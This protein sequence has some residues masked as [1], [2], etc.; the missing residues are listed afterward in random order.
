MASKS[1][2]FRG[3][4]VAWC[5]WAVVRASGALG[6]ELSAR[7]QAAA[8]VAAGQQLQ[9][10]GDLK[11][12][13]AYFTAAIQ[14]DPGNVNAYVHRGQ[15]KGRQTPPDHAGAV[16]DFTTAVQLD[17]K[18]AWAYNSRATAYMAVGDSAKA[19]ADCNRAIE[20]APTYVT[21][22]HNRAL[23]RE[24]AGDLAGAWQDLQRALELDPTNERT[25]TYARELAV[26]LKKEGVAVAPPAKQGP[27]PA[28][29]PADPA[30]REQAAAHVASGCQLKGKGD[31]RGAIAFFDA[32]IR[33]DPGNVD[34]YVQR[35]QCKGRL[36]PPDNAG[37]LAD[38]T[39]ALKLNP[40]DA[41][42][43]NSR[44]TTYMAMGDL[45]RAMADCNRAIEI[46]PSYATPYQNRSL[47]R[48][49]T[50]DLAGAWQD[51]QRALELAPTDDR[52]LARGRQLA[53][54]LKREGVAVAPPPAKEEPPAVVVAPPPVTPDTPRPMPI[55]PTTPVV[56]PPDGP[57]SPLPPPPPRTPP[58]PV[59]FLP[60]DPNNVATW[61]LPDTPWRKGDKP[62]PDDLSD[63]QLKTLAE[64]FDVTK[65]DYNEYYRAVST[66]I[67]CMRLVHGDMEEEDVQR[68]HA[69]WAPIQEFPSPEGVDYFNKLNPLLLE[70]LKARGAL[71]I[72]LGEFDRAWQEAG[73][74]AGY[75]NLDAMSDALAEAAAHKDTAVSLRERLERI[76]KDIEALGDPPNPYAARH[77]RRKVFEA[78]LKRA[79]AVRILPPNQQVLPGAACKFQPVVKGA[80]PKAS[81]E[82]SFGDQGTAAKTAPNTVAHT[83][84]KPG[85]YQVKLT[86]RDTAT[87]RVVG[88]AAAAAAVSVVPVATAPVPTVPVATVPKPTSTG[89]YVLV[90]SN[91]FHNRGSGDFPDVRI[92][93]G[94]NFVTQR[95]EVRSE[96]DPPDKRSSY[97]VAKFSWLGPPGR[98]DP[99][100]SKTLHV[101]TSIQVIESGGEAPKRGYVFSWAPM[102]CS[103]Y[104]FEQDKAALVEK[105]AKGEREFDID[106]A[107]S[108]WRRAEG[109]NKWRMKGDD[110]ELEKTTFRCWPPRS[111]QERGL[112]VVQTLTW[113]HTSAAPAQFPIA[114]VQVFVGSEYVHGHASYVYVFDP[115][116][117]KEPIALGAPDDPRTADIEALRK[118][119]EFIQG[120]LERWQTEAKAEQDPTRAKEL[121]NRVIDALTEI[122]RAEDTI[123]S[124]E[125]GTIVHRRSVAEDVQFQQVIQDCHEDV[126]R[127]KVIADNARR[128]AQLQKSFD[129]GVGNLHNLIALLDPED[130]KTYREW[131][132]Q[133]LDAKAI[134]E[135]DPKKLQRMTNA[136]LGKVQGQSFRAEAEAMGT[137]NTLEEVNFGCGLALMAVAPFAAAQGVLAQAPTAYQ[138][139][140]PTVTATVYGV[141][142]GYVEGG[143]KGAV[144]TGLR[145]KFAAVDVALAAMDGFQ[146]EEGGGFTGAAKHAA[147]T[148]LLRKS[149]ELSAKR[150]VQGRLAA[151]S[152]AAA[153]P[154]KIKAW[155]EFVK[156]A[157]FK[158]DQQHG[159]NLIR[160][161]QQANNAFIEMASQKKPVG[162][163]MDQYTAA[164]AEA[165]AKTPEGRALTDAM[166]QVETSYTA[167]MGFQSQS[168]PGAVK[169]SYN[170]NLGTF[171]E[172]PVIART[173][174]LM[175]KMGWNEFELKQFRHSANQKKVGFDK[176]L[177]VAGEGEGWLPRKDGTIMETADFQKDLNKC[178]GQA[179]REKAGN[180]TAKAADWRGTTLAD[181]EAYLDKT[182]LKLNELRAKGVNPMSE[183][184][185]GLADHTGQVN[186]NKVRN[187]LAKGTREGQ[188][189]AFRST[190]KEIETKIIDDLPD[191]SP[192][193]AYFEK[194][195]AI[196]EEGATDPHAAMQKL[197]SFTGGDIHDLA[198]QVK[199]QLIHMIKTAPR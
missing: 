179:F 172:K 4:A 114:L 78:Y 128:V 111:A 17:P 19:I 147:L 184:E 153:R 20:I 70:F 167:K 53:A 22:Y 58:K 140:G 27:P 101:K 135:R 74:A 75:E 130:A 95:L 145:F 73:L 10:K 8:H 30:A 39:T 127:A 175:A 126:L 148:L 169:H 18:S 29:P 185:P 168:V 40:N 89:S 108:A 64:Q 88:E 66:A 62:L 21:P 156:D 63:A 187:A 16:A 116:G 136:I 7:E 188:A 26:R 94:A 149:C 190:K 199:Q 139:Y 76:G 82:W 112:P 177:G 189:E 192:E 50:G 107:S 109:D 131:A 55:E 133:K 81:F 117:Q 182:V 9:G 51:L 141:G 180:R 54:R 146:Q 162:Q 106:G 164:N 132:G 137:I 84:P 45:A 98:F 174:E 91:P 56:V 138:L 33:L 96:K 72:V 129:R 102:H 14:L 115:S 44:A 150:I 134:M 1:S 159:E 15:C 104:F 86:V 118:N 195:L 181:E 103:V 125:T 80:P 191:G 52:A 85:K 65:L 123:A 110:P 157:N 193:K 41:R 49:A 38:F 171:L 173:K 124:I 90:S 186:V 87:G 196:V 47:V 93:V 119:I 155:N 143:V 60:S 113:M 46:A 42:V 6:G 163:T 32:A 23:L 178:L 176:D 12:A 79:T 2:A 154:G 161:Y 165:L 31:Y 43:C 144:L 28:A 166:A 120:S 5:V 36:A 37:A 122:S 71:M 158:Q 24:R 48:E 142:T 57:T 34:G 83:Y 67:A 61:N 59:K 152:A 170:K 183:L 121:N 198:L 97:A 99:Q 151:A 197:Q 69:K 13:I 100:A 68:F 3:A 77:R 92:D 35:G 160:N 11:G 105:F 25:L 194:A